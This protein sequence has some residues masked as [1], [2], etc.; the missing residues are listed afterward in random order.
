MPGSGFELYGNV[1]NLQDLAGVQQTYRGRFE[2]ILGELKTHVTTVQGQWVGAGTEGFGTFNT[3]AEG[4]F[5]ELQAAFN[6][7]ATATD[8]ASGNWST[9]MTRINSRW[10]G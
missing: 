1:G 5:T 4:E 2:A 8:E 10:G 9:A 3:T 7:F 6:R